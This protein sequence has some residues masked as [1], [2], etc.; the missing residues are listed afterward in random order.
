MDNTAQKDYQHIAVDPIS[1][2]LGAE[3]SG[4]NLSEPL[5]AEVVAE[6][7]RALLNHLVIF[8]PNQALT[9][10]EQLAFARRFG[11][12]IE[13]PQLKG[14]PECPL[15]TAVTKLEHERAN[16]GGVWALGHDVSGVSAGRKPALC[17]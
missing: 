3:I 11:S 1:G 17:G 2:A 5:A 13:Y 12:P 7:R 16:F 4:V 10:Q 8:F 15:V 6:I 14:L 9:P